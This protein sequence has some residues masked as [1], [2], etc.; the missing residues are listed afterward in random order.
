V[1]D[2]HRADRGGTPVS[3]LMIDLD[4]FKPFNDTYGHDAGDTVLRRVAVILREHVRAE[5]VVCRFGGE[6]FTIVMAGV[7]T[8]EAAAR[9][10]RLRAA[11]SDVE[12]DWH[13][14]PLGT[15]TASFGVATYPGHAGTK[16]DLIRAADTALYQAKHDGRNRVATYAPQGELT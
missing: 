8:S 7:D 12:F 15:I 13:G 4:R 5:D 10:E 14:Q 3:L 1:R 11:I 2:L 9:A 16:T 6:E